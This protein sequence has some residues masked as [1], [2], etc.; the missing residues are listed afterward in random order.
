MLM[1][2]PRESSK[3]NGKK[4]CYEKLEKKGLLPVVEE[5]LVTLLLWKYGTRKCTSE[6]NNPAKEISSG[7]LKVLPALICCL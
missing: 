7:I 2:A 3:E 6:R 5:Y 1:M 4:K